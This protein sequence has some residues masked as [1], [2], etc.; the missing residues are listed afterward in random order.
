MAVPTFKINNHDYTKYLKDKS[1]LQWSREN[2]NAEGAGRDAA[3]VMHPMVLSHQ[4]VLDVT[5][6]PMPFA[7]VQQ[8]EQDLQGHDDG[9]TVVYPDIYNGLVTKRLFY[10]TSISTSLMRFKDGDVLCD[11]VKFTLVSVKEATVT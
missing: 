3:D 6:G 1:G 7:I 5:M 11:N 4:R 9:V 2:T 8:L 10:N